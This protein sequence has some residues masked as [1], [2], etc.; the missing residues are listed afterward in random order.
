MHNI[1]V[2]ILFVGLQK[3]LYIWIYTGLHIALVLYQFTHAL[4]YVTQMGPPD[5]CTKPLYTWT[6]FLTHIVLKAY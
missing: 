6:C 2:D 3:K 1:I 5:T 4:N